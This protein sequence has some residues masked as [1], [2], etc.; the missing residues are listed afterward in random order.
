M[1]ILQDWRYRVS[2]VIR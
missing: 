2:S 1:V